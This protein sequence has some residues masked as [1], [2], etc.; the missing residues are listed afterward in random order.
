MKRAHSANRSGAAIMLAL[1][2]LFLLSAM[3][4]A[5]A[6]EINSRLTVSG[7]A[8]RDLEAEAMAASGAAMAMQ[9]VVEANSSLLRRTLAR[10]QSYEARMTGE[11]GRL[12]LNWILS[13]EDPKRLA[14][15]N[16]YLEIKGIDLNERDRMID[17]L[18]DYVDPDDLPR[19]NG[20]ESQQGYQPKNALFQRVEELK[21]VKGW[22]KIT[23]R[24]GWEND[25][26]IYSTGPIDLA[27]ASRD[28]LLSLPGMN[29]QIV[30]RYLEL[31]HGP[32]GID[33]TE[34]DPVFETL[35]EVRLALGF[36]PDQ[37]AQLSGLIGF[38][39]KVMRV[40]SVGK[41]GKTTRTIEMIIRK[42]PTPQVI[43][44]KE[45]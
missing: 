17:T 13:G 37:F 2:A 11:G 16:R 35:D 28:V 45:L 29:E 19:L 40:V 5:W 3:V 26:T 25:F 24:A 7:G 14:V 23:S 21:E 27:W 41:S 38:K 36:T 4:I 32:D 22:E 39:D 31:R 9:P 6:L 33:G 34:D 1:W 8:S 15:L 43:R 44:W 30:D 10:N 18:L 42:N 20:A 12:H